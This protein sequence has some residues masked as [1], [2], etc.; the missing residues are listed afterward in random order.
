MST[1]NIIDDGSTSDVAWPGDILQMEDGRWLGAWETGTEPFTLAVIVGEA[2]DPMGPWVNLTTVSVTTAIDPWL[3]RIGTDYFVG[4]Q[5]G[6]SVGTPGFSWAKRNGPGDWGTPQ[7]LFNEVAS[8][9]DI[10]EGT[11]TR[12]GS[13]VWMVYDR[14]AHGTPWIW[15]LAV[16]KVISDGSGG[17][18]VTSFT[19]V[20]A[21]PDGPGMGKL[22]NQTR[23]TIVGT[24]TADQYLIVWSPDVGGGSTT[25]L[26]R[27]LYGSI[28][29]DAGVTWGAPFLV[30]THPGGKDVINSFLVMMPEGNIRCYAYQDS[31]TPFVYVDSLDDGE[32][33][34]G[35]TTF[36]WPTGAQAVRAIYRWNAANT[37]EYALVNAFVQ[38]Q[39]GVWVV[40]DRSPPGPGGGGLGWG[41]MVWGEDPWGGDSVDIPGGGG[42]GGGGSPIPWLVPALV[43]YP[44]SLPSLV[45]VIQGPKGRIDFP[46]VVDG[47]TAHEENGFDSLEGSVEAD[48]VLS[49]PDIYIDGAQWVVF[50]ASTGHV[51]AGGDLFTPGVT[52]GRANLRADGWGKRSRRQVIRYLLQDRAFD[53]WSDSEGDPFAGLQKPGGGDDTPHGAI[54]VDTT[55]GRILFTCPEGS[56]V[57]SLDLR[58]AAAWYEGAF[59]KRLAFD[60]RQRFDN[61]LWSIRV[62][63]TRGPT[64]ELVQR[65]NLPLTGF[66]GSVDVDVTGAADDSDLVTITFI[67]T[68]TSGTSDG[69]WLKVTDVRVNDVPLGDSFTFADVG[70][71]VGSRMG[72]PVFNVGA[73]FNV[74]PYQTVGGSLADAL[75]YAAVLEDA[76]WR[77]TGLPPRAP[78]LELGRWDEHVWRLIDPEFPIEPIALPQYDEIVVPTAIANSTTIRSTIVRA[79]TPL[80]VSRSYGQLELTQPAANDDQAQALG[81]QYLGYLM[82]VRFA[83]QVSFTRAL[84]DGQY[85][86]AHEFHG[87]SVYLPAQ[88][89]TCRV[90]SFDRTG[91]GV[92]ATLDDAVS[93]FDRALLRNLQHVRRRGR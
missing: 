61:G 57:A 77:V 37:F 71:D 14:K 3:C 66:T 25:S 21:V 74:L 46:E 24:G 12:I 30:Y 75:D 70:D 36:T 68:G 17:L 52:G 54:E 29:T 38:T 7:L 67:R 60:W 50:D 80:P 88:N 45:H 92:V 64:G 85:R 9:H 33:W 59:T 65:L 31:A 51:V 47:F 76:Y 91:S 55:G 89:V 11:V 83:G 26:P 32:T 8:T 90:K 34:T 84:V 28:S 49:Q 39:I 86:S 72:W 5:G 82:Q 40:E 23:A 6:P 48:R 4:W 15:D 79:P 69:Q 58:R 16:R 35:P 81:E 19:T 18:T 13:D 42:G 78:V 1:L 43:R 62:H 73:T 44:E 27:S 20:A 93:P 22:G 10:L 53:S 87:G 2:S 63:S 56:A 41:E